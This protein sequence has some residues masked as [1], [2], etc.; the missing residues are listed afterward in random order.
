MLRGSVMLAAA[1]GLL[2]GCSA[3]RFPLAGAKVPGIERM[4][5]FQKQNAATALPLWRTS[6]T[7]MRYASG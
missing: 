2:V 7:F 4:T 3:G 5:G 1:V 6:S